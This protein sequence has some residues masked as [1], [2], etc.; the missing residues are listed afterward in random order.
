MTVTTRSVFWSH[1]NT[2]WLHF[3]V[4]NQ[5]FCW[6]ILKK[7]ADNQREQHI[8]CPM[9][10]F[11]WSTVPF[12]SVICWSLSRRQDGRQQRN[13]G[14]NNRGKSAETSRRDLRPKRK[15]GRQRRGKQ[16]EEENS[17]NQKVRSGRQVGAGVPRTQAAAPAVRG[18]GRGAAGFL[19]QVHQQS[20]AAQVS[21]AVTC[22]SISHH[23][24][25]YHIIIVVINSSIIITIAVTS[26]TTI[27]VVIIS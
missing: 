6:P 10:L 20:G 16:A 23:H 19:P 5:I 12:L 7:R 3:A 1:V 11:L 9:I 8:P 25:D 15:R 27:I 24:D 4:Q 22:Q 2:F 14:D 18:L 17:K 13:G 21:T 26:I